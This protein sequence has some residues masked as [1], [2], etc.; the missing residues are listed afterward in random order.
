MSD[1]DKRRCPECSKHLIYYL[2]YASYDGHGI[3]RIIQHCLSCEFKRIMTEDEFRSHMSWGN[4]NDGAVQV[5]GDK[6]S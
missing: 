4:I 2:D 3:K 5:Y 6:S 1:T